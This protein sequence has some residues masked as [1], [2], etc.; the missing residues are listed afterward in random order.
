MKPIFIE[1][2]GLCAPG[3][4]SWD[5]ARPILRGESAYAA[6]EPAPYQPQ[7]LPPNERRRATA[8]VRLAFRVAEEAMSRSSFKSSELATVFASSEGDTAVLHRLCSAL[9]EDRRQLSP[10][11]FHNSVHNAAAGYWSIAAH[12]KL[13]S[14][15]L[16]AFDNSFCAGLLEATSLALGDDL[17]VLLTAYDISPPEPL[18]AKRSLRANVGIA[19]VLTPHRTD[20]CIARLDIDASQGTETAMCDAALESLRLDNPAARALPLLQG[21]AHQDAGV[22]TLKGTGGQLWSLTLQPL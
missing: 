10:T 17:P 19:L 4:A 22:I 8:S 2:L 14:V 11:D 16:S 6:T 13:P 20:T 15:S 7:L 3:L 5:S 9:A 21:L 1:A 12:S 18:L